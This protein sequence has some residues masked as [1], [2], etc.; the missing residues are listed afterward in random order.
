MS[1]TAIRNPTKVTSLRTAHLE[2]PEK[3]GA[4]P[5]SGPGY[6]A[7]AVALHLA[8]QREEALK[9]LQRAVAANEESAEIYRAMGHIQFELGDF[10]ES[11]KSYR[12]LA[13]LKPQ[14]AM[15]WFNLA[16][17]LER[18][19]A[20]D[21]ASEAFHKA[22]TLDPK[23]LEAQLGLGVCHLRM[24][25]PKSAPGV[26]R[27]LPGTLARSRGRAVRQGRRHAVAGPSR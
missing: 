2:G 21:D 3:S 27:A 24:E 4:G 22:C 5:S 20:W 15:G 1:T 6:L 18:S 17:S 19:G 12:T 7:R 26:F 11:A 25:D 14:Y 9:Q 13:Q 10:Q 16:V 8:G 23:H